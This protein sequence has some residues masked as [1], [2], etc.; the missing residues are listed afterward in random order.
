MA[1]NV[2]IRPPLAEDKKKKDIILEVY[3]KAD[4]SVRQMFGDPVEGFTLEELAY[5]EKNINISYWHGRPEIL[6]LNVNYKAY[7]DTHEQL[8]FQVGHEVTHTL[9]PMGHAYGRKATVIE[10]G[11]AEYHSREFTGKNTGNYNMH[12]EGINYLEARHLVDKFI[13]ICGPDAVKELRLKQ[14]FLSKVTREDLLNIFP[15][16]D[17]ELAAQ[18]AADFKYV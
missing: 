5:T 11:C 18:L 14:P 10:E 1:V 8:H 6:I 4:K 15:K 12:S 3:H 16:I 2:V 17:P 7:A 9:G 13:E